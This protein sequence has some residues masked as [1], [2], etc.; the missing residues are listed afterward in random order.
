MNQDK[1]VIWQ[2]EQD[3]KLRDVI[4]NSYLKAQMENIK[5]MRGLIIQFIAISAAI[6]G[7]TVP[8]LGRTDLVKSSPMLI[9]GLF[10]LLIVIIYGFWYLTWMLQKEN[11]ELVEQHKKFNSYLDNPRDA[12]N[13]FLINMTEETFKQWKEEQKKI[14]DELQTEPKKPGKPDYAL[15]IIFGGFFIAL[16]LIVLSLI[17]FSNHAIFF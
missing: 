12:R 8:I 7:F 2:I 6:V 4:N 9:G 17:D 14:L 15:D 13:K 11:R 3:N 1:Y 16:V 5:L 10:E